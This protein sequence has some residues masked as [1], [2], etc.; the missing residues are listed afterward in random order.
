ML[1]KT[2]I[3]A[4]F[5]TSFLIIGLILLAQNF[6]ARS[7]IE[8][9][10][11]S[12]IGAAHEIIWDKILQSANRELKL[13]A[14]KGEPGSTSIWG[15]RGSRSPISAIETRKPKRIK[16]A[17]GKYFD[18]LKEEKILDHLLIYDEQKNL[19]YHFGAEEAG[20]TNTIQ[21]DW[22]TALEPIVFA[23]I[24]SKIAVQLAFPIFSNGRKVGT[25]V[26]AKEL[27]ELAER[28]EYDT[29][30]KIISAS[31]IFKISDRLLPTEQ[32]AAETFLSNFLNTGP[33][34][35]ISTLLYPIGT[36]VVTLKIVKDITA[37]VN[38]NNT[39]F[40]YS[41]IAIAVFMFVISIIVF[42]ILSRWFQPLNSAI[43]ALDALANGDMSVSI[44]Q[45]R[46][47]EVGQISLAV[48]AFR[49]TALEFEDMKEKSR[50]EQN[51]KRNNI[52]R[53]SEE[54]VS[55]LPEQV[56][57]KIRNDISKMQDLSEK[58]TEN[59]GLFNATEDQSLML[60]EK[61]FSRLS[62]EITDQFSKQRNL[63]SAY[64]RFVPKELLENLNKQIIT[65]IS[66]G[67]HI[68]KDVS[69]LF[70]DIRSFTTIAES[71]SAE[72]TFLLLNNYLAMALPEIT[73]KNGYIDKFIGDAIM[74]IFTD[75]PVNSVLS[76]VQMLKALECFN[77]T[78]LSSHIEPLKIGIGINSGPVILGTLG[79]AN[80]L[81]GTVVGDTVN[82]AARLENLTKEYRC[83]LLISEATFGSLMQGDNLDLIDKCRKLDIAEVRG[84]SDKVAIYEVFAW[85]KSD[86]IE[87]KI[88][89][90]VEFEKA[91]SAKINDDVETAIRLFE[92]YCKNN[93]FDTVA[94]NQLELLKS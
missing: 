27:D 30:A 90:K 58:S 32:I 50:V 81:E 78:K 92:A 57:L 16:R 66:P 10:A 52:F 63:T 23:G 79:T 43:R 34:Y 24:D 48:Q 71:L 49:K 9:T 80:R 37:T 40:V 25:I 28:F 51:K 26:Y 8:E 22:G 89:S 35:S 61:I 82:I 62:T 38:A 6:R 7:I 55:L 36:S 31:D 56:G 86:I 73:A 94:L 41:L 72:E 5:I 14:F 39:S 29:Q 4:L 68:Q 3:L 54:M 87:A 67:D 74:A 19:V 53:A 42:F 33:A 2:K 93:L 17:I 12:E 69:V 20:L 85:E 70:S 59:K 75:H 13:Y 18:A 65:E 91:I 77:D 11:I 88:F 64:Q 83:P 44:E 45:K 60:V 84:K 47:D 21:L 76:A 1:L 15:L 46:N